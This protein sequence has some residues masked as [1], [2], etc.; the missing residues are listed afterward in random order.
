MS[1]D[2]ARLVLDALPALLDRSTTKLWGGRRRDGEPPL[3]R[4][5]LPFFGC[6]IEFGRHAGDLL[7]ACQREH[8]DVFTLLVAGERMTFV[9]DPH[10]YPTIL[11]LQK[12]LT[13]DGIAFEL[14]A[15]AFGHSRA[16]EQVLDISVFR[17]LYGQ[18][19]KGAA[20]G[21]LTDRMQVNLTAFATALE[22]DG[23]QTARLSDLVSRWMFEA[24][25][26]TLFG[27]GAARDGGLD[28]F[29]TYDRAFPLLVAGVPID[30]LPGV[31]RARDRLAEVFR[32]A[33]PHTSGLVGARNAYMNNRVSEEDRWRMQLSILWAS[34][35]NTVPAAFWSLAFL[36]RDPIAKAAVLAEIDEV[37]PDGVLGP[38]QLKKMR[39]LESAMQEALRLSSASL[40]MRRVE[41]DMP[42]SL[43][44]HTYRLRAGDRVCL[45]PYVTH[46]DPEMY[47]DPERYQYDRFVAPDGGTRQFFKN[48]KR[49]TIPLMPYGGGISMCPGRFL[50]NNEVMQFVAM[51][52]SL[53][54]FGDVGELPKLDQSRAGLGILPPVSDLDVT[55]RR[56]AKA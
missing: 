35:A 31:R 41:H 50:A 5:R 10:A 46:R 55:V 49:V 40:T 36:L 27:E 17:D 53:F 2:T 6:A 3:V 56:R 29:R 19:L 14:S 26:D 7:A 33:R 18:H 30:L 44:D 1:L 8:G 52:L 38:E 43:G 21:G 32:V 15:T 37:A 4:G 54:E 28:D 11:K 16:W 20:L 24:G 45:Y 22:R 34:Q 39:K 12:E 25:M 9:L 42:L 47:P 51:A 23:R 13:F 48:G